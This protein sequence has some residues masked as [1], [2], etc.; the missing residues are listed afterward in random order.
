MHVCVCARS[1]ANLRM[2][3]VLEQASI[4]AQGKLSKPVRPRVRAHTCA[5]RGNARLRTRVITH[6]SL[7]RS[8]VTATY[9]P[10]CIQSVL[11]ALT[12]DLLL[13]RARCPPRL[14]P[15]PLHVSL[16]PPLP[17]LACSLLAFSRA[18][19]P[20]PRPVSPSLQMRA[21]ALSLSGVRESHFNLVYDRGR[22]RTCSA[23]IDAGG[24]KIFFCMLCCLMKYVCVFNI[25]AHVHFLLALHV[26]M[27]AQNAQMLMKRLRTMHSC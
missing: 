18:A 22:K 10:F 3:Q 25:Y 4:V 1:R 8:R 9:T 24:S 23:A 17:P 19:I 21:H 13:A 20:V 12:L 2:L 14:P 6:C 16:P 5:H 27:P 26:Q 7:V 11:F 15:L